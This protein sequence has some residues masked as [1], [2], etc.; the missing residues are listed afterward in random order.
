MRISN[1]KL[2]SGIDS[3]Q[4]RPRNRQQGTSGLLLLH[5]R[6]TRELRTL[7]LLLAKLVCGCSR[8]HRNQPISLCQ[9]AWPG[10]PQKP[11]TQVLLLRRWLPENNNK[12]V[13]RKLRRSCSEWLRVLAEEVA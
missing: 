7:A 12:I 4:L 10:R 8:S 5:R 1:R 9:S 6:L 13:R 2:R 11:V 3:R